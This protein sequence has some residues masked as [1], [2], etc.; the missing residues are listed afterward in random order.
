MLAA[1][2]N[3]GRY[4]LLKNIEM[5][6]YINILRGHLDKD[7]LLGYAVARN[8]RALETASVEYVDVRNR[9][10]R[11]YGT[12]EVD[13]AGNE[14]GRFGL[15]TSSTEFKQFRKELTPYAAIEHDVKITKIPYTSVI[16]ILTASEILDLDWMLEDSDTPVEQ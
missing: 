3:R 10:I 2:W 14:T 7:G 11:K 13:A 6:A 9:L 1:L 15:S 5:E 12:N 8:I 16:G 4:M